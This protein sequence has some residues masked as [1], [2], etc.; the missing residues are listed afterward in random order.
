MLGDATLYARGDSVDAAWSL[1]TPIHEAWRND[2]R[3]AVSEYAAGTWGPKEADD[4]IQADG[5]RWRLP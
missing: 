5:R 4:I 3:P 2:K 1:I